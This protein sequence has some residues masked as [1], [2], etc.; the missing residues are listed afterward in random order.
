MLTKVWSILDTGCKISYLNR[1]NLLSYIQEH[2]CF[3]NN[4]ARAL[5]DDK[6]KRIDEAG[7][8]MPVQVCC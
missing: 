5:F 7:P 6:G 2:H 4:Q 3:A 1:L 8:S